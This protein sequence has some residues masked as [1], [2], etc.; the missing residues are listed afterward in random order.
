MTRNRSKTGGFQL[1]ASLTRYSG[2]YTIAMV[3]PTA[4]KKLAIKNIENDGIFSMANLRIKFV[5]VPCENK[6]ISLVL[7]SCV[8]FN[9]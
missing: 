7:A 6:L 8:K 5:S 2:R 9:A 4:L 3:S 1:P